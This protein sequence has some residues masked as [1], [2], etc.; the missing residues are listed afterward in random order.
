[1]KKSTTYLIFLGFF[2]SLIF[3]PLVSPAQDNWSEM[4]PFPG[5]PRINAFYFSIGDKLY[6]G[7]GNGNGIKNMNDFWE[8]NTTTE[9]W[10]QKADFGG[11]PRTNAVGF[12]IGNFG[13]A[14]CGALWQSTYTCYKDFWKYDPSSDTW[15]QVADFGGDVRKSALS[16]SIG[17]KGYVG[18][19]STATYTYEDLWEYD[20][21]L[22]TWTQK[23]SFPGTVR[24]APGN[25]VIGKSA[26][27]C[28]GKGSSNLVFYN[29]VWSYNQD[30]NVWSQKSDFI[31]D[32]RYWPV[33]FSLNNQ[34]Y[35]GLGG[36]YDGS[37]T[38]E[39]FDFFKY[40]P[41]N[42]SWTGSTMLTPGRI[43][44]QIYSSGNIGYVVNGYS[45]SFHNEFYRFI[46]SSSEIN[47]TEANQTIEAFLSF[48]NK[49]LTIN[50]NSSSQGK[51]KISIYSCTGLCVLPDF[52]FD[53]S[54]G[55]YQKDIQLKMLSSGIYVVKVITEKSV[56]AKK[57]Q[58]L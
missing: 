55:N 51:G 37:H 12:S 53:Y 15:T 45:D 50:I 2:I 8:Y 29:D 33:G 23:A 13:Y 48:T 52:S 1:M 44:C 11:S 30:S 34:G 14:G 36:Y 16:F 7:A 4:I 57:I 41:T 40:N 49:V 25:F 17:T 3:C 9:E 38:V 6:F 28:C 22:N 46:P 43:G 54:S 31:G 39:L 27:V 21:S 42:D 18:L 58:V 26:Y 47:E 35:L 5:T 32:A 56:F 24:S 19:G 20:P 10:T